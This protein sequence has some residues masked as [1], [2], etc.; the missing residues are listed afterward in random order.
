[1]SSSYLYGGLTHVQLEE[2]E[3]ALGHG[4][5]IRTTYAHL[6]SSHM[7]AFSPA[8]VGKHHPPPWKA[9]QGG[10]GYDIHTELAVP[11]NKELPHGLSPEEAIWWIAA[12]MRLIGYPFLMVPVISDQ[13]FSKV[14]E[15]AMPP[16][17]Y[18]F[19]T[20]ERTFQPGG[21][22]VME[23]SKSEL[24]WIK[25]KWEVSASLIQSNSKLKAAF[26]AWDF[27]NTRGRTSSSLLAVWGGLEE[28]FS[29]S[30]GELRFRVSSNIAAF[31]EPPGL[32]R[33]TLYKEMISLYNDR[34]KAAHTASEVKNAP[35][36]QSYMILRNVLMRIIETN[37]IPNQSDL[38]ALLFCGD[39]HLDMNN[40]SSETAPD[41][42]E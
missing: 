32:K 18:S 23:I 27:C 16:V 5:I 33:L 24:D 20:G 11:T 42:I 1:M 8:P 15:N 13:S 29:P 4:V 39:E 17:L 36:V 14:A 40:M 7:M 28:L 35:L 22:E 37:S 9:A 6:M 38:E 25:Q 41:E 10:F 19:E 34:S 26:R 2:S 12:L 21:P 3:F 30:R 31:L